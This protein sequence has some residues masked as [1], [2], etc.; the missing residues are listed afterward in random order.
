MCL[1]VSVWA[2]MFALAASVPAS[3]QTTERAALNPAR[4]VTQYL[5]SAWQRAEGLPQ[6]TVMDVLQ[7]RDGYLWATTQDG[8]ARFD[9]LRFTLFTTSTDPALTSDDFTTL[10]E[11]RSGTLWAGTAGGGLYTLR[12]GRLQPFSGGTLPSAVVTDLFEDPD[13][14]LWIATLGG[15]SRF[16]NGALTTF[17]T[18]D[19]LPG[20]GV[21]S[22]TRDRR[23]TLWIATEAG[24][25]LRQGDRFVPTAGASQLPSQDVRVVYATQTG[26]VLIGTV[27]GLVSYRDGSFTP[28]GSRTA[29]TGG[30]IRAIHEDPAGALWIGTQDRGIT[31]IV[32][33]R[34]EELGTAQGFVS[35]DVRAFATDAEGNL[36]VG[37]NIG[38]LVRLKDPRVLAFGKPEGLPDD[39]VLP[40]TA[41]RAGNLWAGTYGGGAARLAG[42]TWTTYSS[43]DGLMNDAVLSL[44]A[45]AD[46]G[47][48]VGTRTGVNKI[49]DGRVEQFGEAAGLPR[50]VITALLED[51]K[52]R[53]WV[54]TRSGAYLFDGTRTTRPDGELSRGVVFAI[55][56]GRDGTMWFGTEG[57]GVIRINGD[58][59]ATPFGADGGLGGAVVWSIAEDTDGAIWFTTN[60]RGVLRYVNGRLLTYRARDGLI[61]DTIYRII[62]DGAGS[63]WLSSN[64]GIQRIRRQQFAAFD[65]RSITKVSGEIFGETDGMRSEECN[66]GISPAG[67][68]T[69]DGVLWFPTIK[70]L[71]RIDP[72]L[73]AAGQRPP[74]VVIEA[75][76]ADGREMRGAGPL[77]VAPGARSLEF[78]YTAL[79]LRSPDKVRFRYKLEGFDADWIDGG[80]R[81]T[82]YYTNL[83]PARYTFRVIAAN[84]AGVWN[85]AGATTM[86]T[87]EPHFSQTRSFYVLMAATLLLIVFGLHK[88]RMSGLEAREHELARVAEERRWALVALQQSEAQFRTLFENV[89]EAVYRSTP[90]G[91]LVLANPS[92]ARLLGY[93]SVDEILGVSVRDMYADLDEYTKLVATLSESGEARA[94]EIRLR[95]HDGRDVVVLESLRR[96]DS[97]GMTY[98]EGTLVDI[99]DRKHLEE[100]LLQLQRIES[101]G[102]LAGG[103]AHDV[104]NLLT[105]ILGQ[106]ELLGEE[107]AADDPRRLRV[108]QIRK[109]ALS[110]R[111]FTRQLLAFSRRQI[112][113]RRIV[114]V[115][116]A[117]HDLEGILRRLVGEHI[118]VRVVRAPD[119]KRVNVDPGQLEQ[120]VIN[121]VVNAKD[122]MPLGGTLTV[123]TGNVDVEAVEAAGKPGVAA[124]PYVRITVSDTGAGISPDVRTRLFEPFVTTKPQGHGLGLALVHGIVTQSGGH[125]EVDSEPGQGTSFRIYLPA[126]D[127]VAAEVAAPARRVDGVTGQTILL[128]EDEDDV[129]SITAEMLERAGYHVLAASDA[130]HAQRIEAEFHQPIDLL[131]TDVVMPGLGGPALADI[132]RA[133]RQGLKVLYTT[134]YIDDDVAHHGVLRPDVTVLEKPFTFEALLDAVR[135]SVMAHAAADRS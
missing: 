59:S 106:A 110:A 107:L 2:S 114:D 63:L 47:M 13:G 48:W 71:A 132:L 22:L 101:I 54:G 38:G 31:R 116:D 117:L 33:N 86:V 41:D 67:W 123:E 80:A 65:A 5:R 111:S 40:V 1:F 28:V 103:V 96:V 36:W 58:G 87:L 79:S 75:I 113:K 127:E 85:E 81:R 64:R 21:R 17:T 43:R 37:T 104:N 62:D 10:L 8:L 77:S 73:L 44:A 90:D 129:R 88:A 55:H 26:G 35:D 99:T 4:S 3:G 105:P 50:V 126:L 109:A 19:G 76:V 134:G 115:N 68:R 128:V 60:A 93:D 49:R 112:L 7:A 66:G 92:M 57:S 32:G 9:G 74:P 91:R 84:D 122:A 78:H 100:Q 20:N 29:A 72:A 70:G 14:T 30:I 46:G 53:L 119:L 16:A 83:A 82:A 51:R 125:I 69:P 45:S 23:G 6:N 11:D 15:L 27:Q 25:A 133:R 121:L 95:T 42:G 18:A 34:T 97:E 24:I 108:D 130:E 135:E 39:V 89:N 124:G 56:E 131:L 61:D 118:D 94:V 12:N 120:V 102:R 52:G 98:F